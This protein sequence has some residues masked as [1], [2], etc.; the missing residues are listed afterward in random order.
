MQ[1]SDTFVKKYNVG[2]IVYLD[3]TL[4]SQKFLNAFKK[5]TMISERKK[6]QKNLRKIFN[7]FS[8]SKSYSFI[9]HV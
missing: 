4:S 8:T 2:H 9:V 6:F 3:I 5:M 7:R 1:L